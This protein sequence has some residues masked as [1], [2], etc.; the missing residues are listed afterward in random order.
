[1]VGGNLATSSLGRL[2]KE[3]AG[4]E[5]QVSYGCEVSSD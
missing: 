3:V 2:T 5:A 1:M 4:A